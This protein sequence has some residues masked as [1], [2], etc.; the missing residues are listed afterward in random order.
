MSLRAVEAERLLDWLGERLAGAALQACR[1]PSWDR[2]VLSLRVPGE[3]L[4]LSLTARPGAAR[5]HTLAKPPGNPPKPFAFQGLLRARLRGPLQG[6][7]LRGGD[8]LLDLTFPDHHLLLLF[9]GQRADLLLLDGEDRILG[10]VRPGRTTGE[11]FHWDT[12]TAPEMKDRFEGL[13]GAER[14][15]AV[16]DFFERLDAERIER[17]QRK[18]ITSHRKRLVRRAARQRAE[19]ERA[20]EAEPIRHRADLLRSSFHLIERGAEEVLLQDWSTGEELRVALD[21]A[22]SPADN[23]DRLYKKAARAERSGELAS[24][25]LRQTEEELSKL[26][27]GEVPA[28][29]S[30]TR[31][32]AQARRGGRAGERLPYRAWR[33]P[34]G[35][36]IRVG[37]S[38]AD[39]DA[40]TFRHARGNDVWLHVRGRPGAHVVIRNPGTSPSPELLVI[41]AQLA[42][43]HS[44]LKEGA[45]EEVAWTRV[46]E[47]RKP[48][49][50]A[51]G[52]VLIRSE[53]VLYLSTDP[54]AL[55]K[56]ERL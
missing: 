29:L 20:A 2:V 50:L 9:A 53:K 22:L 51:P 35:F 33:T 3:T 11:T 16:R 43:A 47:V 36:E 18:R 49:G 27:A 40:L 48:K 52:K 17:A 56:L 54:A 42:L 34:S 44:G 7:S 45:R 14:S 38:A 46:K 39:N 8:R 6:L 30:R 10:G 19:A 4:H 21:P 12:A 25:R 24:A 31:S 37:R 26:D 1:Q 13:G 55:E 23:L 5:F 32:A 15:E 41:G 28:E